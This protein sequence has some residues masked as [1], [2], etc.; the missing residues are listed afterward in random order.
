MLGRRQDLRSDGRPALVEH[1]RENPVRPTLLFATVAC[2]V[3]IALP[4]TAIA[5]ERKGFWGSFG[6]GTGSIGVSAEDAV[7]QPR[8]FQV[9]R[10][11]GGVAELGLGWAVN[12]QLLVGIE[13]KA[14]FATYAG[15]VHG[16]LDVSNVSGTVTYYSRSSSNFFVKGGVGGSFLELTVD[17][18]DPNVAVKPGKGFG[19]TAGAGYDIYLGR[20]FSLTPA[21]G[22]WY[23]RP[24]D[25]RIAGQTLL[26]N[27]KHNVFDVTLSIKF[28]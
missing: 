26:R 28:N 11:G 13:V 22:F 19:L 15:D 20:G 23:G 10:D 18:P 12:Q 17:A 5:Q 1:G 3:G 14:M 16:T 4:A 24:G 6:L 2:V 21:A 7:A 8:P 9:G 27:W 25:L